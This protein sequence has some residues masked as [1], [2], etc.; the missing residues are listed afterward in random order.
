[1]N[2]KEQLA[3]FEEAREKYMNNSPFKCLTDNLLSHFVSTYKLS[4]LDEKD[5]IQAYGIALT[6]FKLWKRNEAR[7]DKP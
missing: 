2:K 7:K 1:M 6:K 4:E 5:F 3:N